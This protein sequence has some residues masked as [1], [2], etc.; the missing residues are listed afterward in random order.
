VTTST[1][2]QIPIVNIAGALAGDPQAKAEA[3]DLI[4]EACLVHGFFYITGHGVSREFIDGAFGASAKFY[5]IPDEQKTDCTVNASF[6]G[7]TPLKYEVGIGGVKQAAG[8]EIYTIGYDLAEDDPAVLAGEFMCAPNVWPQA[9]PEFRDTALNYYQTL[10]DLGKKVLRLVAQSLGVR[11]DFFDDKYDKHTSQLVFLHY[12]PIPEDAPNDTVSGQEHTD[13]G[14]I[15]LLAQDDCGG[16][17]LHD[18]STNEW[19]DAPP[20]EDSFVVN[21]ADLMARWTNNRY[22]STPHQVVNRSRR[23]RYS[24]GY[25]YNPDA[26]VVVAPQDLGVPDDESSYPPI[27]SGEYVL[28]RWA[29][30]Y[31]QTSGERDRAHATPA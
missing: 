11:E 5:A 2:F 12:P 7:H 18:R 22:V 26:G 27:T 16:L 3:I 29:E 21:L 23:D 8:A 19:V 9:M 31:D 28:G 4:R 25:F 20:V 24:I 10:G 14:V 15:T 17:R 1:H 30:F 13:W 6:R